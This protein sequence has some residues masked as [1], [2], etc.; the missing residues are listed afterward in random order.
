MPKITIEV[1]EKENKTRYDV[2]QFNKWVSGCA[3][4]HDAD[5]FHLYVTEVFTV[6]T[7]RRQ[8]HAR[9]LLEHLIANYGASQLSL[10]V[11]PDNTGAILLYEQLGFKP[12]GSL[13]EHGLQLMTRKG[14]DDESAI[15][16]VYQER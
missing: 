1:I 15:R 16:S 7:E 13:D 8:G 5:G 2:R 6:T 10:S 12:E 9:H 14:N 4:L 3:V 11:Y